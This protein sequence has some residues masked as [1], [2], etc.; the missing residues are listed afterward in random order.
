M[1]S[2]IEAFTASDYDSISDSIAM[3]DDAMKDI[4]IAE[5]CGIDCQN[6][7]QVAT[8]QAARLRRLQENIFPNGRPMT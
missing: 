3:L 4:A 5:N 6:R 1:P 2:I 8:D 7:R